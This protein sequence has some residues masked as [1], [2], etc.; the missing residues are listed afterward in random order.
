MRVRMTTYIS[1]LRAGRPW[2]G[3]G[4]ELDVN[5][6]EGAKLCANGYAEPVAVKPDAKTEKRPARRRKSE[7]R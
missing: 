5:E 7:S 1:G 2:P 4:E 3:I 6:R